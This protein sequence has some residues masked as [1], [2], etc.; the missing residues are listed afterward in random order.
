[1]K[2]STY[3]YFLILFFCFSITSFG[4]CPADSSIKFSCF[5]GLPSSN[6]GSYLRLP[7]SHTYEVLERVGDAYTN[8]GIISNF[9]ARNDF[10]PY[11]GKNNNSRHGYLGLNHEYSAPLASDVSVMVYNALGQLVVGSDKGQMTSGAHTFDVD[12]T[13]LESGIYLVDV[14]TGDKKITTRVSNMK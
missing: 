12:F 5:E 13:N 8:P 3:I 9:R 1:M 7:S 6:Q 2:K 14:V 11:I 10:A 4:Q